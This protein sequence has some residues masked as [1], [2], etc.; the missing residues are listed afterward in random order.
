MPAHTLVTLLLY[1]I[2]S[3]LQS[4]LFYIQNFSDHLKG[5]DAD[6]VG[7]LFRKFIS[8]VKVHKFHMRCEQIKSKL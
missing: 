6:S 3:T 2:Y 7:D 8:I 5:T 4:T 1:W